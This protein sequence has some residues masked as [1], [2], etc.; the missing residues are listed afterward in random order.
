MRDTD[1]AVSHSIED[2]ME[3][4]HPFSIG[5][6]LVETLLAPSIHDIENLRIRT[7]E[8]LSDV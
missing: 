5:Q 2:F 6:V 7:L 3:F 4:S 1:C 8:R